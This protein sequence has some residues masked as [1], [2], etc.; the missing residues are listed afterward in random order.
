MQIGNP[1]L[2]EICAKAIVPALE[3][4]GLD[5]KR[6]DKHNQGGL[7]KN[8]IVKFI[9][10]SDIIVA[11]LTNE[12][13]NCYLEIGYA[14]GL[15]KFRHLVLTARDDHSSDHPERKPGGPKVHFD[16]SGYDVLFWNPGD[17]ESFRIELEKRIRRR[18]AILIPASAKSPSAV[19]Q[20]DWFQ[21]HSE[22]ART[23]FAEFSTKG[24]MEVSFGLVD[25]EPLFSQSELLAAAQ[26]ST[27]RTFG[28][29]IGVVMTKPE[30][31]PRPTSEGIVAQITTAGG[32]SFDYWALSKR[33]DF[34]LLRDLF[35]DRRSP[36]QLSLFINT[37]IVQVTEA[38]LYAARLFNQLR[39]E[40]GQLHFKIRHCGL[41]NR[42]L[43][44]ATRYGLD[45]DSDLTTVEDDCEASFT[46]AVATIDSHLVD[47]VKQICKPL[48]ILFDF[49]E[50]RDETYS[51]IVDNFVAGRVV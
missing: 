47:L 21:R 22:D 32:E 6:V 31:R 4:C 16:L 39:L 37:R 1:D 9:E 13:P 33:V 23:A 5:A 41:K 42:S 38:I 30:Y 36:D 49:Y 15:D 11:D 17:L 18:L 7:L 20:S 29:P 19:L 51:D 48:F 10:T 34:Y 8:E 3:A 12:R 24:Y 50:V 28:W 40:S 44:W 25:L 45:R 26:R 14:M 43:V 46:T 35:E 2:D 27:I